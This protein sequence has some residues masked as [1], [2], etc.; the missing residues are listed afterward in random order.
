M[1][2]YQTIG[3]L[4]IAGKVPL[5]SDTWLLPDCRHFCA[6]HIME[7]ACSLIPRHSNTPEYETG[8]RVRDWDQSTR[9]G[10]EYETR[11]DATV[12]KLHC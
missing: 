11:P 4:L 1:K 12:A 6:A 7:V 3:Y 8:T 9:L 10:P 5:H 2:F